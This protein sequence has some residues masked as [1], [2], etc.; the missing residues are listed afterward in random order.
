MVVTSLT[1]VSKN[2]VSPKNRRSLSLTVNNYIYLFLKG[3]TFVL[4]S[5][6]KTLPTF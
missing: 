2:I 6:L 3:L 1:V 5:I 4:S